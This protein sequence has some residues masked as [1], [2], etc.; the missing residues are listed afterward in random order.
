MVFKGKSKNSEADNQLI[1]YCRKNKDWMSYEDYVKIG[2][3]IIGS[4]AI[5]SNHRKK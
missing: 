5:E 1:C 4:G 2:G 3:G